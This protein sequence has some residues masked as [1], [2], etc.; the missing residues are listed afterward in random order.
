MRAAA[1]R[2]R[3]RSLHA[4][5][6]SADLARILRMMVAFP[7]HYDV[8]PHER[9][10]SGGGVVCVCVCVCVRVFGGGGGTGLLSD[11]L[12]VHVCA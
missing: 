7:Y 9:R 5:R 11:F 4:G 8:R 12:R 10:G 6:D 2:A 3:A 1:L